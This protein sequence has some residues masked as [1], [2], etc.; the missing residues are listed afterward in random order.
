MYVNYF[1]TKL[2]EIKIKKDKKLKKKS[3][4]ST[5][6][7]TIMNCIALSQEP[8]VWGDQRNLGPRAYVKT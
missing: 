7:N 8:R 1:S 2:G 3:Q 4:E 5:S 6:R